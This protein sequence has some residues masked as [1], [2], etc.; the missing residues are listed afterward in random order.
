ME[1][2]EWVV[3]WLTKAAIRHSTKIKN[4]RK[5]WAGVQHF[6]DTHTSYTLNHTVAPYLRILVADKSG[7]KETYLERRNQASRLFGFGKEVKN[8]Y[9]HFIEWNLGSSQIQCAVDFTLA[10]D[11]YPPQ[12]NG[13]TQLYFS[14]NFEWKNFPIEVE[15]DEFRY[16]DMAWGFYLGRDELRKSVFITCNMTFPA[17]WNS[18]D[19]KRFIQTIE[20]DLPFRLREQYFKRWLAPKKRG[21][22]GRLLKLGKG[23]RDDW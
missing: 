17:P 7:D 20:P 4:Q 18:P 19:L 2:R 8:P 16:S 15:S 6:L 5:A 14:C 1:Q 3:Y 10:D 21:S 9:Q 22:I 12:E 23:W 11:E 13:P